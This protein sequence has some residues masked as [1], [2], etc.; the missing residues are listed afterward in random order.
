MSLLTRL[1]I[2]QQILFLFQL[3]FTWLSSYTCS[4]NDRNICFRLITRSKPVVK[5]SILT[6]VFEGKNPFQN[7]GADRAADPMMCK[8]VAALFR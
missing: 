6:I 8:L 2:S 3:D 7:V 4:P 5:H 1:I